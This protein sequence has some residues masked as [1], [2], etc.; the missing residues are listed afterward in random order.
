MKK[1]GV[2]LALALLLLQ[3]MAPFSHAVEQKTLF[4]TERIEHKSGTSSKKCQDMCSK[5]SGPDLTSLL[6]DGWVMVS[7]SHKEVIAEKYWYIP[8]S[9]CEPHGCTCIGT[10]YILRNDQPVTKVEISKNELERLKQEN[11][12]LKRELSLLKQEIESLKTQIKS[13]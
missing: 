11:G 3:F 13:K 6:A 4:A 10:E 1:T 9:T 8:C 2:C 7:S 12:L 5:R